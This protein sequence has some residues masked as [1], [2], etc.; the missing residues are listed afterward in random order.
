L[1]QLDGNQEGDPVKAAQVTMAA[2]EAVDHRSISHWA[3][4]ARERI[5]AKF[6]NCRR[7]IDAWRE[8]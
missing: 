6:E 1:N 2:V 7:E 8:N 4:N 3:K 5:E